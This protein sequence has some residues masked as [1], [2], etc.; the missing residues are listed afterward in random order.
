MSISTVYEIMV[1]SESGKSGTLPAIRVTEASVY[2]KHSRNKPGTFKEFTIRRT[3]RDIKSEL[4]CALDRISIDIYHGEVFGI[5]GRNGAGKST[6]LKIISKIIRPAHGRVQVWGETTSLLGVGAGFHVEL[7]GRENIYLYSTI[8]GRS[9][10]RTRE[11]LE[12][13][14]D[15]ADLDEFIDSPLR[16]YSTGMVARL[17][18]AVAMAERPQILL[19][20]EVLGVGDVQFRNKCSERFAYFQEQGSTIVIVTHS[21]NVAEGMCDRV[22][23]LNNGRDEARGNP[24]EVVS[25][26][27]GHSD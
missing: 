20:D 25:A 1:D 2:Y 11:L 24:K 21:M 6:F 13:I 19:V 8:L 26:Y 17:G 22:L 27:Q 18:F 16:T 4:I 3:K 5:I 7:T 12:S 14:V 15:F 23:W 10:K 9:Q